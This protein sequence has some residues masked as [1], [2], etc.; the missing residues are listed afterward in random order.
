MKTKHKKREAKSFDESPYNKLWVISAKLY[1]ICELIKF[2]GGEPPLNE[3]DVN[4]GIGEILTDL[5]G[6]LAALA[7][8]RDG[9]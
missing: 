4:F 5:A 3:E 2:R 8:P 1:G 7:A 9:N 6:E